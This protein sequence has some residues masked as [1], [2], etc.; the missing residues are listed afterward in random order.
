[1]NGVFY[2][3]GASFFATTYE[4]LSVFIVGVYRRDSRRYGYGRRYGYDTAVGIAWR[5]G[6]ENSAERKSVFLFAHEYRCVKNACGQRIVANAGDFLGNYARF[7]VFCA[8][9][10][11][12]SRVAVRV[13]EK[14]VW[15]VFNRAFVCGIVPHFRRKQNLTNSLLYGMI[16]P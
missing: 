1:M 15:G 4:L 10:E 8:G 2:K 7:V 9:D 14:G 6:T 5:C 13:I 16:F 3:N 12:G 11:L